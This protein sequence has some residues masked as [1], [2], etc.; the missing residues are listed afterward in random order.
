MTG[1]KGKFYV[2]KWKWY[3]VD[4]K[5][6]FNPVLVRKHFDDK[7]QAKQFK[8]KYCDKSYDIVSGKEALDMQLR[9]WFNYKPKHRHKVA[10]YTKYEFPPGIKTQR[11]KQIFRDSK[12][13]KLKRKKHR[14]MLNYKTIMEIIDHKEMLFMVRLR[15][16]AS[17]Y[18]AYSE[19]VKGFNEFRKEYDYPFDIVNLSAIYLCLKKYYDLGVY[20]PAL[21]AIYIYELFR[22]GVLKWRCTVDMEQKDEEEVKKEFLARGFIPK[23]QSKFKDNDNAFIQSIHIDPTLVYPEEAWFMS[24]DKGLYDNYVYVL[25]VMV[26]IQ[27]YT[28]ACI[29]E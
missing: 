10:K 15:K 20:D 17:Y 4:M 11:Q 22:E 27:G 5:D 25:Q 16:Y 12:R 28:K 6:W 19:P 3:L 8:L 26:G 7:E 9:D 18:K 1:Y 2:H 23:K 21:V 14:P 29:M 13:K 24:D